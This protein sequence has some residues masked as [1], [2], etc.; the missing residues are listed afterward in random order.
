MTTPYYK[1]ASW[2]KKMSQAAKQE[3]LAREKKEAEQKKMV[4]ENYEE[5]EEH[6]SEAEKAKSKGNMGV[7]HAHMASHHE[8]M[9]QWHES[10]GRHS[11]A[12]KEYAKAEEHHEN[13]L[14][15][16]YQES[17]AIQEADE[18]ESSDYKLS[19]TGRKV[20]AKHII[21]K[22]QDDDDAEDKEKMK[23]EGLYRPGWMLNADP[24]LKA[25][26]DAIKKINKARRAAYGNPA[27]GKSI[28][29]DVKEQIELD[30]AT[31]SIKNTKTGQIYFHSKY[32]I[33]KDNSRLKK[34]QAAGGDH[35]H[36][37]PH[38]DGKPMNEAA[39]TDA[40]M[41]KR[42]E[43]V[44]SMKKK[45]QG[46]KDRY[47][48]RAKAVM[49]ATA[50]KM[51]M[52]EEAESLEEEKKQHLVNVTL[53]D[54]KHTMVSKRKETI[55]RRATVTASDRETAVNTALAHY[56]KQGY[57]VHDHVYVGLKE[58]TMNE[59]E[60]LD[61]LSVNKMLTYRS[62]ATEKLGSEPS[63]DAKRKEGI[64]VSGLKIKDKNA[65]K[66]EEKDLPFDAPYKKAEDEKKT[67]KSGAVHSPMS[68][69]RHLARQAMKKQV[70]EDLT[71]EDLTLEDLLEFIV[72]EEY[73][74]LD[75]ISKATLGSYI[76]KA[77]GS[78]IGAAQVT[79]MGSSMTGQK[80]QDKAERKVQKRAAGINKAVDRLTREEYELDEAMISYTD[81][82]A[83]L[84]AHRKAGNDIADSHYGTK[85]A[86]YTVVDKEGTARKV[87]HTDAGSKMENLGKH[88]GEV[89]DESGNKVQ[90]TV[91]E[92]A[93]KRGRGRPAG[94]T[95]LKYKPRD[96]ASKAAS[97]AKAAA[98]KAAN[99]A[100]KT[101]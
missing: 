52:K 71:L 66:K 53:S 34:I 63:K 29:R 30:E 28:P 37:T 68:R 43:I 62:K 2:I 11:A 72:T 96:P 74:Q 48:D 98:S 14:K 60:Q 73:A 26:I 6:K 61:E 70:K 35:V 99:R 36:A 91:H 50:T 24:K 92:P 80:T 85:K 41:K 32:P 8:S 57:K 67:D 79:G 17:V 81:F 94:L 13:S 5:A 101:K 40:E 87:T 39:M 23:N 55:Q 56:K 42:E 47:G 51:A 27:A 97:A 1:K 83:K 46:F 44:K 3:R 7:Y 25:K 9:G 21:F 93:V 95:G 82:H 22:S 49:Y 84:A 100:K 10:K 90:K 88:K 16:P 76:K 45:I 38:K 65:M 18:I 89:E 31:Y 58:E 19:P 69:A 20:R 64:R 59:Q 33:T 75:E 78:A 4:K 77:K 12:D 15:H 86:H 54:P